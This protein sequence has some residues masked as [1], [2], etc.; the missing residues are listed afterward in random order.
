MCEATKPDIVCIVETWLDNT[1]ADNELS[2]PN[3]QLFRRD[4]NRH[5]GGIALYV[6]CI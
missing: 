4:C 5:G 3:F 6:Q 2:L 1:I